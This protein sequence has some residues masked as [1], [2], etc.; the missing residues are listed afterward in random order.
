[1]PSQRTC[2]C[3]R[4]MTYTSSHGYVCSCTPIPRPPDPRY[5]ALGGRE[6]DEAIR[7]SNQRAGGDPYGG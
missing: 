5:R 2:E 3:G 7:E 4:S 6:R 1:M